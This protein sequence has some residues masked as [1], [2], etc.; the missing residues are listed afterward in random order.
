MR[1]FIY[2]FIALH[3]LTLDT[4]AQ[5][6]GTRS[7]TT[8]TYVD[9]YVP[10][11]SAGTTGLA[12]RVYKASAARFGTCGAPIVLCLAGGDAS[13]QISSSDFSAI[14]FSSQGIIKIVFNYPGGGSGTRLSG[15]T[16]DNRGANCIQ[17]TYD[18]LKFATGQIADKSGKY[19][20]NSTYGANALTSSV[21]MCGNSN[22]GNMALIV[23]GLYGSTLSGVKGISNWESPVGDGHYVADKG[24]ILSGD[25]AAYTI[26]SGSTVGTFD[27]SKLKYSSSS[28]LVPVT[29][30]FSTITGGLYF[31]NDNDGA[32]TSG[33]SDYVVRGWLANQGTSTSKVYYSEEVINNGY[34]LIPSSSTNFAS[35][36]DVHNFWASRNGAY[37]LSNITSARPDLYFILMATQTDH[38]QTADDRPHLI[39]QYEGLRTGGLSFVRLNPD[40]TYITAI[41]GSS[42]SGTSDNNANIAFD[43]TSIQG[44]SVLETESLNYN[45]LVKASVCE[46]ADRIKNSNVSSNLTAVLSKS[47]SHKTSGIIDETTKSI[48]SLHVFP[49][50]VK[51]GEN[52]HIQISENISGD[53]DAD[54]ISII[55]FDMYGR[56]TKE[57]STYSISENGEITIAMNGIAKG[58]YILNIQHY[59]QI[60]NSRIVITE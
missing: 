28:S 25:N 54:K 51:N 52:L 36:T 49:N 24:N 27:W 1:Y 6:S 56:I 23:M 20:T 59:D 7:S 31:D 10:S 58:V 29:D 2:L 22:G 30:P 40:N 44:S 55:M 13:E 57:I 46:L 37:Y 34:S 11:S 17:A 47:C 35:A 14:D 4:K 45:T 9:T 26:G 42:V 50:P 33:S 43:Y 21:Q 5:F 53:V 60:E 48:N 15:G 16:Y 32:Y 3:L 39:T 12:V 8:S 38:I 18:V 41:N 19:I